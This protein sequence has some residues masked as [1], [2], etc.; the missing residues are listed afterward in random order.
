MKKFLS[1][2]VLVLS[3]I[4]MNAQKVTIDK[5]EQ[6]GSRH[7]VTKYTTIYSKMMSGG[8]VSLYCIA[9]DV[10]TTLYLSLML[11]E[12]KIEIDEGRKLIIKLGDGT[13]LT[14]EN[15]KKIGP[16]DYETR[17]VY[18]SVEYLV[19]PRYYVSREDVI[20]MINKGVVKI[21]I[22]TDLDNL[23]REIKT[24]KMSDALKTSLSNID[25]ALSIK[26]DIYSD[27]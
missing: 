24:T 13:I 1:I 22:E 15:V 23:D 19:F 3:T 5:V 10:D 4:G 12:Q 18:N 11:N 8:A 20:Q 27:F 21:R 7:V 2:I 26:K 16:L 17:T 25:K 14:L 6:D 9:D